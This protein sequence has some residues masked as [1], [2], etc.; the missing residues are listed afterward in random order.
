[1]IGCARQCV[2]NRC[3]RPPALAGALLV[4]TESGGYPPH[5]ALTGYQGN[6]PWTKPPGFCHPGSARHPG[7][8]LRHQ[9]HRYGRGRPRGYP[10]QVI[11]K[12]GREKGGDRPALFFCRRAYY[13]FYLTRSIFPTATS[14]PA[15]S[16]AIYTPEETGLPES[17][18]PSQT[19][20][21][22]PAGR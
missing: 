3:Q 14:F 4:R 8:E 10:G 15:D 18:F 9:T 11:K 19:A 13:P 5:P 22:A 12:A 1:M 20:V 16:R 7:E 17:S 21:P 2:R 6:P